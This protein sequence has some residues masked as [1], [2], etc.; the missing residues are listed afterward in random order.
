LA[1]EQDIPLASRI[2]AIVDVYDALTSDRPY[3]AA[4]TVEQTLEYI[5][6]LR[7]SHFD[8][9]VVDVFLKFLRAG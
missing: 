9:R 2:F 8:P 3:R 4:W 5:Q 1:T 6:S 7:G